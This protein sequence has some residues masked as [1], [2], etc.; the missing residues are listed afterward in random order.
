[1]PRHPRSL[2][3]WNYIKAFYFDACDA[4]IS[5]YITTLFPA[6]MEALMTYYAVD[7]VQI[8]TGFVSPGG[9]LKGRRGG[10]H[11]PGGGMEG[12]YDKEMRRRRGGKRTWSQRWRV[13]TGFDPWDWIG[14]KGGE[15]FG[16]GG[17]P[18]TPGV[19]TMWNVYG[20]EQRVAY[21]MMFAEITEQFFY[22]WASGVA[23]SEYCD[24]QYRPWCFGRSASQGNFGI[25]D[26]TPCVIDEVVK[27]RHTNYAAGNAIALKGGGSTCVFKA[28]F[29]GPPGIEDNKLR[30]RHSTGIV[31]DGPSM[32]KPGS[33]YLVSGA[34]TE[35]GMWF[36]FSTGP[37]SYVLTDCEFNVVGNEKYYGPSED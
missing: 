7:M 37:S 18:V 2:D 9:G 16:L 10:K 25:L 21:Y 28:Q 19:T 23:Q 30:I 34:A 22:K 11:N 15:F 17:R 33:I 13:Y 20:L 24:A 32:I 3:K 8:F 36:F 31:V 6:I 1:M 12:G 5:I 26:Q 35:P 29:V 27:M 4:P 14:R